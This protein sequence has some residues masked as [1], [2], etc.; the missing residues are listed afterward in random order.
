MRIMIKRF[1]IFWRY[2]PQG[3]I[4]FLFFLGTEAHLQPS[5]FGLLPSMRYGLTLDA[6]EL[7]IAAV[8]LESIQLDDQAREE[9]E[10]PYRIGVLI[11]VDID[12]DHTGQ[13]ISIPGKGRLWHLT[14]R[15]KGAKALSPYFDLL[16]IPDGGELYLYNDLASS[17]LGAYTAANNPP[18]QSFAT[19]FVAGGSVTLEYFE[20]YGLGESLKLHIADI[21][22]FYRGIHGGGDLSERGFGNSGDCEVNVN[23]DEGNS[24]K[25]EKKGVV[26][27]LS[28]VGSSL[29]WCTGSLVNNVKL[30]FTPYVLTADHCAFYND[31]YA[32]T[33][34][35]AQ[36]V[37]YFNYES[38]HCA[39]PLSEPDYNTL[40]GATLKA[41]GGSTGDTGS[42]FYLVCLNN[43]VPA[44]YEPFF[45]GW[46]R[47]NVTSPEGV[48]IHHP[49]G[50]IKKISTYTQPTISTQWSNNGLQSHWLVNWTETSHGHGVTESGSSGS[51]LFNEHGLVVGTLTGGESSCGNTGGADFYGK[52]SYHWKSN[53]S[54]LGEQLEPWLDPDQE[55]ILVLGGTYYENIV[56]ALF[57][58]DTTVVPINGM[59]DFVDLSTGK[60]EQWQWYFEE[61]SPSV[62]TVQNPEGIVYSSYGAYDVRLICG[63]EVNSDTLFLKDY[64]RVEPV[65]V[66]NPSRDEFRIFF[67]DKSNTPDRIEVFNTLGQQVQFLISG[68]GSSTLTLDLAGLSAGM[69]LVR[70]RAESYSFTGKLWLVP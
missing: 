66:P 1:R 34:D 52:L 45:L 70:I 59:T 53:G 44:A 41:H 58:A 62:S 7:R 35:L 51:P 15:A 38:S 67:G 43:I 36:W 19:E 6:H 10:Y 56:V 18:Y 22:Y 5:Q 60:P 46:D 9:G 42:D 4:V 2:F 55:G 65:V 69:Y 16:Y 20:P 47:Q 25:D 68:T 14:L 24:W 11:P 39:D 27:I 49:Q 29:F 50:D 54:T 40:V 26:R 23:C 32:S 3:Y 48:G 12:P 33:S 37:F 17:I 61:G 30:D 31:Q 63:N 21:G 28:R 64:I 57:K 8:D 13:W